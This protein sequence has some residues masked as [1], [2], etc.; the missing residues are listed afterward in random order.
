MKRAIP[1]A[2]IVTAAALLFWVAWLWRPG[3]PEGDA[4]RLAPVGG[5]FRLL[6][7]AGPLDL[8]ALRGRV[9]L[10]YFGYTWCPDI[11]PTNLAVI[12]RALE[13]LTPAER[14]LVQVLFVT[15]D[16]QRD[17][18]ARLAEY[19]G[20]FHPDVIGLTGGEAE[21][22]E[23]ARRYGAAFQRHEPSDSAMGYIVDHSASSYLVD[24]EGRLAATLG[25]AAPAGEIV[26]AIRALLPPHD[27]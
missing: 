26:A 25:H 20:W 27:H 9:V 15:V 1:I 14:G 22:A 23:V 3:V 4:P 5:D 19:V 10:I 12:A 16:P 13:R 17:T 8:A 11:C 24:P 7:A 2:I 18:A 21:I 6:S